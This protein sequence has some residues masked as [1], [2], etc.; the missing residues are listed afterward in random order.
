[1]ALHLADDGRHREGGK[2]LATAAVI[3]LDRVEQPDGARLDK[4][5]VLGADALVAVGEL[6]D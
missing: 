3:A 6:L 2:L 5:V 4:V 1:V